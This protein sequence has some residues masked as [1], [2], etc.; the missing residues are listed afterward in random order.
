MSLSDTQVE[1]A[2]ETLRKAI[3]AAE[4]SNHNG[5]VFVVAA[6]QATELVEAAQATELVEA[7]ERLLHDISDLMANSEGVTGL[8]KNGDIAPWSDLDEDG[9]YNP[10]LGQGI[11]HLRTAIAK[12]R[13]EA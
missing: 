3:N 2:C 7:A 10:W 11:Y 5:E 12:A 9:H 8:H 4:N 1:K 13:G 6:A